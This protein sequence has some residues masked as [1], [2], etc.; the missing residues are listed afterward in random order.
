MMMLA[1]GYARGFTLF[2]NRLFN[3]EVINVPPDQT[4]SERYYRLAADLGDDK[5][6]RHVFE[7]YYFGRT[8]PKNQAIADQYLNK[9]A[10]YGSEWALV[11]LAQE[12]E[13][14]A[15]GEALDA[16]LR[17]ARNNN[18]V[19][20]LRLARAYA[21]GDLVRKNL[22]QAYFWLLLAKANGH[23]RRADVGYT[24]TG[25]MSYTDYG[26]QCGWVALSVEILNLELLGIEKTLPAKLVQAAQD[27]ATN[28]TKGEHEKLLPAPS[29]SPVVRP[30]ESPETASI[31]SPPVLK[32]SSL[33]REHKPQEHD[34]WEQPAQANNGNS[35]DKFVEQHP[36]SLSPIQAN[37][38][39]QLSKDV[40]PQQLR[41]K[42]S[43]E[44]LFAKVR[45]SVWV[46]VATQSVPRNDAASQMS[47]GSAVAITR[48]RLLTNCH[49]VQGQRFVFVKQG[50]NVLDATLAAG[51]KESD[52][53]VLALK[54]E[55][56]KP[57]DGLR[58]F[59]DLH[60]GEQVYTIGSPSGLE[61]TLGQGIVS[62]LRT[63]EGQRLVQTTAPISPGSSGGGLFDSA[64]N[65][66]G[67]TS[68]MLKDAQG[69][70]FAIAAEDYFR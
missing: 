34:P 58:G 54:G 31:A 52:R 61:S 46:V 9:A 68:F 30:K 64:G 65:L 5:A 39:T 27:T 22:T 32:S 18:C 63:V 62:G 17:L 45:S 2:D 44:D 23:A 57:V 36:D 19:A 51:D 10:R 38:W 15:P 6:L 12:K 42:L 35:W 56:L 33:P 67:I 3:P 60:V 37:E 47:Q 1:E 29:A 20:Q 49:V 24:G 26:K 16:Y 4:E 48:S 43:A 8:V 21:L 40:R 59:G 70:N 50:D 66:V 69:L 41:N 25:P 55:L 14:S 28:W 53:C 13:K 7:E 11:L